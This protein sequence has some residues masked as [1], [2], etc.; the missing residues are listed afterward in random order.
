MKQRFG[1]IGEGIKVVVDSANGTGGVVGPKLY[2]ALGCEVIELYSMP[3]GRFP[4]HHPNPSDEKTLADIKKAVIE[5]N[6]DIGI[7]YDGDSDRIGIIDS[8][9]RFLTGDKLLLIYAIDL[10]EN[11]KL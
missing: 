4:H 11:C 8:Q 7:A 5:N 9:G 6:A 10:I 1:R 2:R 3:D